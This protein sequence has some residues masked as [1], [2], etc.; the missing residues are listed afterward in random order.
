MTSQDLH[1]QMPATDEELAAHAALGGTT[2]TP[3]WGTTE[4]ERIELR[5][6]GYT[7]SD[8]K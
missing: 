4:A 3:R 2:I 7:L 8:E 5:A 6:A 1:P